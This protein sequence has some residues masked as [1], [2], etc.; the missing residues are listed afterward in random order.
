MRGIE[1]MLMSIYAIS[2]V[3]NP[4]SDQVDDSVLQNRYYR[5]VNLAKAP[6]SIADVNLR[7]QKPIKIEK[8]TVT[9]WSDEPFSYIEDQNNGESVGK[10]Y[11]FYIFNLVANKLNFT[12]EIIKPSPNILGNETA[13]MLGLLQTKK[14]DVAV[15]FIPIMTELQVNCSFSPPLDYADVTI[16]L[17]R[18]RESAIGS[19]LLAPFDTVV[20]LCILVSL[21]VVGPIIYVI[22]SYRSRLWGDD[23][24]ERYSFTTCVWFTYGALLKQGSSA[25]PEADSNRLLFATWWIYITILTS[26]YTA[27]LTAFLT[28]SEFTLPFK[29]IDEVVYKRFKWC[30]L[31]EH[32]IDFALKWKTIEPLDPLLKTLKS[33][34]KFF[35]AKGNKEES[36][37]KEIK[38]DRIFIDQT[39]FVETTIYRNYMENV[40]LNEQENKRCQLVR[41]PQHVY[42]QTRAFAYP[43]DS[44]YQEIID[45]KLLDLVETGIIQYQESINLPAVK[46]CPL[47][48]QSTERQLRNSD[49]SLTY[50]TI[51]GGFV[52]ATIV[53]ITE[54]SQLFFKCKVCLCCAKSCKCCRSRIKSPKKERPKMQLPAHFNSQFNNSKVNDIGNINN[55]NDIQIIMPI[56][57]S[58][59]NYKNMKKHYINGRDYWV[60]TEQGGD[61]RLVPVR[62]PSALLFQYTS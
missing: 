22:T 40:K 35:D 12:Y 29:S 30:A 23:S 55:N 58:V 11:A 1:L 41:M 39:H 61:K 5:E 24:T 38:D 17:K 28:L 50:K 18:P 44:P 56:Y 43:K 45:R 54:I 52:F 4:N 19:G 25:A 57:E 31:S 49:L 48:L 62:S 13:G 10:G 6:L 7:S 33:D 59:D 2:N 16:L 3:T 14:A 46:Y 60:I 21:I 32:L 8:L 34:G 15:A 37:M 9:S 36:V 53:F 51:G 26:F 27:N 20:W 42:H 47:N